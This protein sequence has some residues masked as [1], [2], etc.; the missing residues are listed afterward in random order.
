M[1]SRHTKTT[2]A[3]VLLA[4][5]LWL[6][7]QQYTDDAWVLWGIL[8]GVGVLLPTALNEART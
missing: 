4:T 6:F 7:A 3:F 1:V 2:A 8:V 5:V